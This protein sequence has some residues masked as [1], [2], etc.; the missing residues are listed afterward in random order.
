MG[1]AEAMR[2][3]ALCGQGCR[4]RGGESPARPPSSCVL[5]HGSL[6]AAAAARVVV[7]MLG[8]DGELV[9]NNSTLECE[10]EG[11][12]IFATYTLRTISTLLYVLLL[13]LHPEGAGVGLVTAPTQPHRGDCGPIPTTARGALRKHKHLRQRRRRRRMPHV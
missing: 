6:T 1:T 5:P 10:Q 12:T 11:H 8:R 9:M 7:M 13:A 4:A 3:D 2:C